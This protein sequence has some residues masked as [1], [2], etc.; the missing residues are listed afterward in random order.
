MGKPSNQ[1]ISSDASLKIERASAIKLRVC[2]VASTVEGA[3]WMVEQLRDLRDHYGCDVTAIVSGERGGLIDMLRAEGIPYHVEYMK[4][5]SLR[6][7]LQVPRA[8]LRMALFFRR[9]RFDVVQTHLFFSML[10]GRIAAW[11]A[12]VPVRLAMIPGPFHLEAHISRWIDRATGWMETAFIPSCVH[13]LR[14]YKE[15]GVADDRL[16]LIYYGPDERNFIPE[17]VLP[18]N[19]R[20]E[21]G[22]PADTPLIAKVAYFYPPLPKSRWVPPVI[23]ERGVKGHEYLVRAAPLVLNEF[24]DAKFLLVGPGWFE[25]GEKHREEIKELVRTLGLE[26]SVIFVGY[27]K[28]ANR[29]LREADVAVQASLTDNPA[30]T[31]EALL[32]ECPTV[33]TRVGGMVDTVRDGETGVLVNPSDPDD[34]ARGILQMLRDRERALS[35]GRAGRKLMLD[36]FTL[37]RAVKDLHELY[38]RLRFRRKRNFYNPP[39]SLWRLIVA[40][41]V[42]CY[43]CFRV[44]FVD[45]YIPVYLPI[46]LARLRY[47]PRRLFYRVRFL[48]SHAR[49]VAGRGRSFLRRLYKNS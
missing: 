48:L 40:I 42:C 14:L 19:I 34:M 17:E 49:G 10:I 8:I 2:H 27:R 47:I 36:R 41:P 32:M 28:D 3:K 35:L 15:I 13:T 21:Y 37:H 18:A 26:E 46:H 11:L 44:L 38:L 33:A 16:S 1:N 43:L 20:A 5:G 45:T 39:V 7:M 4:F 12:D 24:P 6:E 29:I 9:E 31:V 23:Q 25:H 30:G 22:W